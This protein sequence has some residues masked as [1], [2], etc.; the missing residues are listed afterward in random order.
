MEQTVTKLDQ[1]A[2]LA[3]LFHPR[4]EVTSPPPGALDRMLAVD[5][6]TA[7]HA[8]F[9]AAPDPAAPVILFFHGNGEVVSDYDDAGAAFAEQG[10]GFLAVE[11]R[12]YGASSGSP[13]VAAMLRDAH[14][15]LAHVRGWLAEEGHAGP[16]L[17]MGRSLGSVPA[18]ELAAAQAES[19]KG[20]ILE[21]AVA[22][23]LPLLRIMGVDVDG[24]GISEEDGFG[25]LEK[26]ALV[27][28]PTYI[29]HA[30]RDEIIPPVLAEELQSACAARSKEFQL[31]PGAGHNDVMARTG[32]LYFEAISRFARKAAKPQ[33]PRR[34]GL[35][36]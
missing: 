13:G 34:P 10:V 18:I 9:F 16:L 26:I 12:G 35:R 24:L 29:L 11:Y 21:S 6:D 33:R 31:I 23:T 1:P 22:G 5:D 20:L 3:V 7:V 28:Q 17:V 27:H 15:V 32:R 2:V 36:G 14:V 25:N 30:G 19:I 4:Q 8:R